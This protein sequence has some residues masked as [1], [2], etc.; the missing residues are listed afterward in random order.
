MSHSVLIVDDDPDLRCTLRRILEREGLSVCEA[1]DGA[2]M[3]RQLEEAKPD[4]LLLD[5]MLKNENG[6]MLAERVRANSNLPMIVVSGKDDVTDR[7]ESLELG[8]DD[9][10][11][12]PFHARELAARVRS[13]LR[14]SGLVLNP[15]E[16]PSMVA[17]QI[18]FG[19]WA[20]IPD[21]GLL[22][23]RDGKGGEIMLT[24]LEARVLTILCKN[25]RRILGR[26]EIMEKCGERNWSP[27]DRSIDVVIGKLRKK[28]GDDTKSPS[29]IR[30][31]RGAGYS[32]IAGV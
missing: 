29:Y 23:R 9:Y 2:G 26:D 22:R 7:I 24:G 10:I 30:T 20:F 1:A 25:P 11:A 31:V 14:R 6:L 8:A 16:K 19:A 18:F 13:V 17:G 3:S 15:A 12:K 27:F 4:L 32:M 21:T 28:L 5:L